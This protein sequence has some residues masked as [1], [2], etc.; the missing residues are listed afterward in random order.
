MISVVSDRLSTEGVS[1][2]RIVLML[3]VFLI[4]P[5][6]LALP[7]I[8]GMILSKSHTT[9]TDYYCLFFCIAVYFAAINSTK[10]PGGDQVQYY[11]AYKNVP[12]LGFLKSL[13]YIYGIDYYV[14]PTKSRISGEFMNGVFN[15]IGY[16][17]TLGYYPLYAALLTF[18]DYFLIFL[19]LYKFCL[20]MK[21][22]H[23]PIVCGV[24]TLSFFYL[25][26]NYTLQIQKQFLAQSIM[27]YVLGNYAY[28]GE[29]RKKDWIMAACA[30]FTHA[31]T[32]LLVP[33]L[34]FKPLHSRLTKKGLFFIG[35]AFAMLIV[36]GPSLASGMA[37]D[38]SST[39][40]YGVSRLAASEIRNDTEFGLVWSQVFVI[41][42]PMALITF[43]KLWLD[44]KTLSDSNAFILNITLLLLLTIVA[45]FRQPLAQYRYFMMLFAFMPFIYPF[46]FNNIRNRDVL[47]KVIAVVMIL[48][49]YYQFELIVWDYASLVDII[50]KS[51]ILLLFG[52]YY[53]V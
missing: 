24:T 16:Y 7:I 29:M 17:V 51:P 39:L 1:W 23:I 20:T 30:V 22:P 21:K 48:W 44:R 4:I 31:A 3:L 26:F 32:L 35:S 28:Y 50:I 33:F 11:Y 49:F 46:A 42:L 18:A 8:I 47:L 10:I 45:M 41:A 40:T 5:P 34:V 37:T 27:M 25:F 53:T 43:R 36:M 14:E 6:F 19:G 15:Y 12:H 9:K 2:G 38:S 52:N 13:I